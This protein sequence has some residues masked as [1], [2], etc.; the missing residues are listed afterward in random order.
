MSRLS[1]DS[2]F[3][4]ASPSES[5]EQAVVQPA[6]AQ[7]GLWDPVAE[8]D[9]IL[10]V[11]PAH[12]DAE[13]ESHPEAPEDSAVD[14]QA[15][16]G[17][18]AVDAP[19]WA[20]EIELGAD[21]REPGARERVERLLPPDLPPPEGDLVRGA[22][23]VNPARERAVLPRDEN[24]RG[25]TDRPR[26]AAEGHHRAELRLPVDRVPFTGIERL[27]PEEEVHLGSSRS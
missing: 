26:V 19:T 24:V 25:E 8:I 20:V 16:R 4:S 6:G 15:Q 21:D 27:L 2:G 5:E 14:P 7:V 11:A 23:H 18:F 17:I 12:V 3:P 22:L 1:R 9:V 10:C 13:V